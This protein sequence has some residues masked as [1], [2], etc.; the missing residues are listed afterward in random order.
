MLIIVGVPLKGLQTA[1][2]F[3]L[4]RMAVDCW[5]EPFHIDTQDRMCV[6][7]ASLAGMWN[8]IHGNSSNDPWS[9]IFSPF[10]ESRSSKLGTILLH[11]ANALLA[12]GD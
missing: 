12:P 8:E 3:A 2:A 5:V 1:S 6:S 4:E 9:G 11:I 10:L 7:V